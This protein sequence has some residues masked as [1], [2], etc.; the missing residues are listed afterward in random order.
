MSS[1]YIGEFTCPCGLELNSDS[2][3]VF[4]AMFAEHRRRCKVPLPKQS[5]EP[6]LL[7]LPSSRVHGWTLRL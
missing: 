1:K 7:P 6:T 5:M 4:R 3:D 2:V